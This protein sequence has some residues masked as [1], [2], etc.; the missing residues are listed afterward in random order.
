DHQTYY[1]SIRV[2]QAFMAEKV[3]DR[4]LAAWL[5]EYALEAGGPV[6]GRVLPDHQWFWDGME[7]VDPAKEASAQETRLKNHTTTLAHEYARQ[8]KDWE[9]ELR[10]RARERNLML[11][12]GLPE[13]SAKPAPGLPAREANDES[14]DEIEEAAHALSH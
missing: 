4:V 3:L 13:P 5:W 1:K 8:G 2:D 7:H 14:P 6:G 9:A 11:E 10:Q 12:L